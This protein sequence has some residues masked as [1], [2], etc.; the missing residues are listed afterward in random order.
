MAKN[1]Q[2][3]IIIAIVVLLIMTSLL[4]VF[5]SLNIE[6]NDNGNYK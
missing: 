6:D 2:K 1:N 3:L 4:A 5:I